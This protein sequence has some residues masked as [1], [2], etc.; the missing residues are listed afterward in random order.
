[1]GAV[2]DK[3]GDLVTTKEKIEETTLAHYTKVLENRPRK[4]GLEKH[5]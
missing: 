4:E 3:N 5:K 1:M 2:L